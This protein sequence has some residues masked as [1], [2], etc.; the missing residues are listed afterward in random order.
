MKFLKKYNES[1]SSMFIDFTEDDKKYIDLIFIDFIDNGSVSDLYNY[2]ITFYGNDTP[3][4]ETHIG[5][6]ISINLISMIDN[7]YKKP[8]NITSLLGQINSLKDLIE[9]LEVCIKRLQDEFKLSYSIICDKESKHEIA[10]GHF[11]EIKVNTQYAIVLKL[12]KCN[13]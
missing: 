9:D 5:Y 13:Q 1:K 12:N 7:K 2:D 10:I 8:H 4:K 3:K 6:S 11:E